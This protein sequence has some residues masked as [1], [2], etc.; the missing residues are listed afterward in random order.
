MA[1]NLIPKEEK[2]Y[3]DKSFL[4]KGLLMGIFTV[5]TVLALL[6]SRFVFN[7]NRLNDLDSEGNS[8]SKEESSYEDIKQALVSYKSYP[9]FSALNN[10]TYHSKLFEKLE[11]ATPSNIAY[12]SFSFDK[13]N[14]ISLSASVKGS[15]A[16]VAEFS[17]MLK[18][19]GF[20]NV[21]IQSAATASN[22]EIN[23]SMSFSFVKEMI[24]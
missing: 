1:I 5:L 9:S 15:Y 16:D 21:Q 20:Q 3:T 18:S 4:M 23:F 22:E 17:K 19:N 11:A 10:H 6:G 13:E 12:S 24:L 8:L 14:L 2:I 7:Q